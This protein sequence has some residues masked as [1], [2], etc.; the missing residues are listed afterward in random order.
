MLPDYVENC[1]IGDILLNHKYTVND[2]LNT[3]DPLG[4]ITSNPSPLR[5]IFKTT[6]NAREFLTCQQAASQIQT[7]AGQD[8]QMNSP[9]F[10]MLTRKIFGNRINGATLLA[11]SMGESYGFFYAG[12]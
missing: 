4:L 3:T 6:S 5:G 8:S 9:T 12:G 1:V 10:S 11:N 2:L 7:L